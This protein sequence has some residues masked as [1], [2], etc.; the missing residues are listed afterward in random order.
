MPSSRL[1]LNQSKTKEMLFGTK[2]NLEYASDFTI[3]IQ[4]KNI[5][6]VTKFSYLGV[7]ATRTTEME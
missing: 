6:R 4:D 3:Q 1:V 2:H 7:D 5:E